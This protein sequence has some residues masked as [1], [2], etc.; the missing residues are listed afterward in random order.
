MALIEVN[1]NLNP[2]ALDAL[3]SSVF[4]MWVAFAMGEVSLGNRAD[5]KDGTLK[6][7]TGEYARNIK[8][9]NVSES[10]IVIEID[11]KV[12]EQA[13]YLEYGT[14]HSTDMLEHDSYRGKKFRVWTSR[15]YKTGAGPR[16]L[17][18]VPSGGREEYDRKHPGKMNTS[19]TA[20]AWVIPAMPAYAPAH[21]LAELAR[22]F[23]AKNAGGF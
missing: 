20:P 17:L 3:A 4:T 14:D 12:V 2:Q 9:V 5:G 6:H 10:R 13:G 16:N 23:A 19:G 18:R 21:H 22:N 15:P 11:E 7:V 8:R 1:T